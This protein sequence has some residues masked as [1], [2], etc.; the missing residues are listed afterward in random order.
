MAIKSP[1]LVV[2]NVFLSRISHHCVSL[3]LVDATVQSAEY[4]TRNINLNCY[5]K[6]IHLQ[7]KMKQAKTTHY[8]SYFTRSK[9]GTI[10]T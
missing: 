9:A 1:S 8:V 7:Q 10:N 5:Y 3:C 2:N 4:N 6:T